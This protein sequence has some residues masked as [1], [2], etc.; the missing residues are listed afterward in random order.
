MAEL[1]GI[2]TAAATATPIRMDDIEVKKEELE[3]E[4]SQGTRFIRFTPEEDSFLRQ[5]IKKY[6]LG[7]WSHILKDAELPFHKS[8]TR[9]SLRMRAD[10][11]GLSKKRKSHR[12]KRK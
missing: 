7:R 6:G 3:K 12:D 4:V 1:A 2:D 9:D 11:L 8:R 5:G 10:T